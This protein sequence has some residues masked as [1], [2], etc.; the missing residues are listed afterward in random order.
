MS[1]ADWQN[2]Q[3]TEAQQ[4]E[5]ARGMM[6]ANAPKRSGTSEQREGAATYATLDELAPA[7]PEKR[8]RRFLNL[9]RAAI[10][11]PETPE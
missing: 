8:W 7:A 9:L 6:N 4:A 3:P 2:W 5:M 11:R 10:H 1:G